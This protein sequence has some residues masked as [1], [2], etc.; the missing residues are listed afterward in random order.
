MRIESGFYEISEIKF[1]IYGEELIRTSYQTD[2]MIMLLFVFQSG[3]DDFIIGIHYQ[4]VN[5]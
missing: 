1:L 5:L 2:M 3:T 4:S